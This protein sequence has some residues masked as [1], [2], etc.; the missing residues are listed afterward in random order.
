LGF[1]DAD[2]V[3]GQKIDNGIEPLTIFTRFG[4]TQILAITKLKTALEGQRFSDTINIQGHVM[5]MLGTFQRKNSRKVV[6]SRN[7]NSLSTPLQKHTAFKMTGI[8][9][10]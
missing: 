6:N 7:I 8:I 4:P 3:C 1:T 9:S 2:E 10:V 5:N